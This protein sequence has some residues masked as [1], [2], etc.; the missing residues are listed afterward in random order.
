[1]ARVSKKEHGH[2]ASRGPRVQTRTAEDVGQ[3]KQ[4]RYLGQELG[5]I[6]KEAGAVE[7][8]VVVDVE[9]SDQAGDPPQLHQR[10]QS[11][12]FH[13]IRHFNVL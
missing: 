2:W 9:L 6:L 11:H 12:F 3:A 4:E 7:V 8:T 13:L 1:M 5:E 10:L